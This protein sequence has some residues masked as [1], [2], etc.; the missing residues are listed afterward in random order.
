LYNALKNKYQAAE[1]VTILPYALADTE[2]TSTFNYVKNAPAYSGIRKRRYDIQ[3]PDIEVINVDLKRL[4]SVVQIPIDFIK[5][6]VE[7]AEFG[8]LKGAKQLLL[9][10]KPLILFECGKG[11]SDYY[12]TEPRELFK[13]MTAEIGFKIF[14]LDAFL[15]TKKNLSEDEFALC[16]ENNSEYYFVASTN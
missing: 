14:T 2:G 7:G 10:S 13:F 6:D 16:F 9:N 8:V 1:V 11:A 12:G 3:N 5:I 4:D 15:N